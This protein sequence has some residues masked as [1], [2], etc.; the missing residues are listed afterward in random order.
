MTNMLLTCTTCNDIFRS[1]YDL[2]NHIKR[3]HQPLVKVKFEN[4]DVT[5]VKRGVDGTFKCECGKGFKLRWSFQRHAKGCEGKAMELEK[6]G[7]EDMHMDEGDSNASEYLE[8]NGQEIDHTPIDCYG[9][10]ISLQ[11]ANCRGLETPGN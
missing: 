2:N 11:L 5:E 4:G 1:R 10:P 3:E 6:D 9:S 7:E 8:F